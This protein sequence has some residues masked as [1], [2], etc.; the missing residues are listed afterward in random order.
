MSG[1]STPEDLIFWLWSPCITYA[2]KGSPISEIGLLS[3]RFSKGGFCLMPIVEYRRRSKS[4]LIKF[5]MKNGDRRWSPEAEALSRFKF[6]PT[7]HHSLPGQML[8]FFSHPAESWYRTSFS[9][10]NR[11]STSPL[12]L[13]G[14]RVSGSHGPFFG[15]Q[16]MQVFSMSGMEI[17]LKKS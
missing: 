4:L 9:Q 8:S 1:N 5:D 3:F 17:I 13:S 7:N 11:P 12:Q 14:A 15:T 6:S 16:R 2:S 10:F